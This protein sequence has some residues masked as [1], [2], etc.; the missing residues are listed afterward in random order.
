MWGSWRDLAHGVN[1]LDEKSAQ[2]GVVCFPARD[3]NI[4]LLTN[5]NTICECLKQ[6]CREC[7]HQYEVFEVEKDWCM[8]SFD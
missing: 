3:C 4:T 2:V 1:L 5:C 7:V 6:A 8:T